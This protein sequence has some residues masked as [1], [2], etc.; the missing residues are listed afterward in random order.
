LKAADAGAGHFSGSLMPR[1]PEYGHEPGNW[2]P[3]I[4][5]EFDRL[6]VLSAI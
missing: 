4:K 3:D 2:Q 1:T 6:H 5:Q